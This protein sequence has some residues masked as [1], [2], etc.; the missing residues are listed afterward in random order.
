MNKLPLYVLSLLL[1]F[2]V[3]MTFKSNNVTMHI[4]VPYR[5]TFQSP[6]IVIN[7]TPYFNLLTTKCKYELLQ[8]IKDTNIINIFKHVDLHDRNIKCLSY[9]SILNINYYSPSVRL[10]DI[11]NEIEIMLSMKTRILEKYI[12]R[13]IFSYYY[14]HCKN[15]DIAI[16]IARF[17]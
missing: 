9:I 7:N 11:S 17:L 10:I 15:D 14:K 2:L 13:I 5:Y 8:I 16:Y 12:T 6:Y 3:V 1:L 4:H